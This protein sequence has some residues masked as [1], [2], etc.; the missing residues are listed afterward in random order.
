ML[1]PPLM[2]AL[3]QGMFFGATSFNRPLSFNA[4]GASMGVS[5]DASGAELL[6]PSTATCRHR[7]RGC[8]RL[9]LALCLAPCCFW[10]GMRRQHARRRHSLAHGDGTSADLA[11]H[12]T[13]DLPLSER[14]TAPGP[15]KD[16]TMPPVSSSELNDAARQSMARLSLA[17][18]DAPPPSSC[19]QI[20]FRDGPPPPRRGRG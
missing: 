6:R 17:A 19:G 12:D 20:H 4:I 3:C 9:R 8:C 16:G 14:H 1:L 5:N 7:A 18:S 11:H 10:M 13:V 15:P 2:S